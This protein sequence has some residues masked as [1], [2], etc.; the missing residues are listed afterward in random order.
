MIC[1]FEHFHESQIIWEAIT[2]IGTAA[3]A[4]FTIIL[5]IAAIV[6]LLDIKKCYSSAGGL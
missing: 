4:G 1:C 2:A 6:Q 5:A 3:L